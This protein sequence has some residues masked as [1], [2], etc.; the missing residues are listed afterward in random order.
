MG[1]V[2]KLKVFG[3]EWEVQN[4]DIMYHRYMNPR[5]GR[6][7]E[8]PLGGLINLTILSGYD[9]EV[10]VR[11]M[12][13]TQEDELCK[14]TEGELMFYKDSF[15][16]PV[17]FAYKFN[18]AALVEYKEQFTSIGEHPMTTHL[19]ISP[20]IQEFRG[21]TYVKNWQQSWVA[22]S[23]QAPYQATENEIVPK[24]LSYKYLDPQGKEIDKVVEGDLTVRIETQ[25]MVGE[26]IT[27]DLSDSTY[28]FLYKGELIENDVLE[29]IS[30]NAGAIDVLLEVIKQKNK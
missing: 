27:I 13:H 28:D 30:V 3:S 1:Y 20:A 6:A 22:P 18:D 29:G 12:T 25:G 8:E 7:G 4:T 19:M 14:L 16:N 17:E 21:Q 10:L 11:W 26:K 2:A 24:I 15:D 23:E 5:S 9:D